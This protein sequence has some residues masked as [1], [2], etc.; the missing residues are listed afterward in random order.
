[1]SRRRSNSLE[2]T[3]I[4]GVWLVCIT[5]PLLKRSYLRERRLGGPQNSAKHLQEELFKT[6]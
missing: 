6:N 3:I 1:L 5:Q 4:L 2:E